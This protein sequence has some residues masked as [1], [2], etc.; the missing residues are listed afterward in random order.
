M[1]SLVHRTRLLTTISCPY[2][3][4]ILILVSTNAK[5]FER[6]ALIRR[7]WGFDTAIF[8]RWRTVFLLGKNDNFAE[9]KK[10]AHESTKYKD[11][12]H[13]DYKEDFWNMT[14]KVAM[15]FEWATKHCKYDYMLKADDDVFVNVFRLLYYLSS[16]NIPKSNLFSKS[17]KT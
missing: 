13:A 8:P 9:M 1:L 14:M 5:N 15:G 11:M 17:T 10:I 3:V 12:I 2:H 7:T 4:F 6:R 16:S